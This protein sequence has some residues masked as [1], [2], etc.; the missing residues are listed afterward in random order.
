MHEAVARTGFH[1]MKFRSLLLFACMVFVPL[2]AMFSHKIPSEFREALRQ[3]LWTPARQALMA[4]L[5]LEPAV[6]DTLVSTHAVVDTHAST[7]AVVDTHASTD[8]VVDS[9]LQIAP[10]ATIVMPA[11]TLAPIDAI[12]PPTPAVTAGLAMPATIAAS[13]PTG[14]TQHPQHHPEAPLKSMA[15][16]KPS[17]HA[18]PA[19]MAPEPG[20][21]ASR[22]PVSHENLASAHRTIENRLNR[23]GAIGF[24]CS[25]HA[26]GDKLHRCSCRVSA[27]PSGQLQRVFQ[28]AHVDPITAMQ[29]LLGQVRSWKHRIAS[30]PSSSPPLQTPPGQTVRF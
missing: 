18:P 17:P 13:V 11:V 28:S 9:P 24:E 15:F 16:A 1:A 25:P 14:V 30:Q 27:D 3:Q 20:D 21:P 6:V 7:H 2:M 12:A 29:D 23:L 4:A 10:A 26:D 5:D 19:H 8:A 22:L